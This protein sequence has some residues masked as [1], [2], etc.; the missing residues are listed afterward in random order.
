[1]KN[2]IGII[3]MPLMMAALI[4]INHKKIEDPFIEPKPIKPSVDPTPFHKEHGVVNLIKDYKL[5]QEGKSKKG[6][7]KQNMITEKINSWI[8][9]GHLKKENIKN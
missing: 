6:I 8:E 5:I 3:G 1:M 4:A 9:S 2:R 7:R